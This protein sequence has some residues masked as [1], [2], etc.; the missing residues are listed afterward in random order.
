MPLNIFQGKHSNRAR[1]NVRK[2]YDKKI[3]F[4]DFDLVGLRP[5]AQI[6]IF[7]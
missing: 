7:V 6:E 3:G 1:F 2:L 4:L 5:A